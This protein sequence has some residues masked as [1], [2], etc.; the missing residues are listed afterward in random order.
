MHAR[1]DLLQA[2]AGGVHVGSTPSGTGFSAATDPKAIAS[3]TKKAAITR[4]S[5]NVGRT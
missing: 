1:D 5:N 4:A 2:F 3:I